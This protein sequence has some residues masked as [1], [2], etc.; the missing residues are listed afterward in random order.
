MY[1]TKFQR[2]VRHISRWP[3]LVGLLLTTACSEPD[4]VNDRI[5]L[6]K[7]NMAR[8][9]YGA[10]SLELANL[11]QS[12]PNHLEARLLQGKVSL[13]AGRAAAAESQLVQAR[14]LGAPSQLLYR[15]IAL[16][17]VAQG[18]PERVSSV[19]G[20]EP[21]IPDDR[22]AWLLAAGLAALHAGDMDRAESHFSHVTR[23]EAD[24]LDGQLGMAAVKRARG[25]LD[26][27]ARHVEKTTRDFPLS[28]AA[29]QALGALRYQQQRLVDAERAF[30]NAIE[31]T[32]GIDRAYEYMLARTGLVETQWHLDKK[33]IA[34]QNANELMDS[35]PWHPLPKY[36]RGLLA[37]LDN[38]YE[39]A[40]DFLYRV[41]TALPDHK[42][43][44]KLLAAINSAQGKLGRAQLYLDKYF[45]LNDNDPE[46]LAL[47]GETYL[48]MGNAEEAVSTVKPLVNTSTREARYLDLYGTA[49][50]YATSCD[51]GGVYLARA[52]AL[53]PA[54]LK[55]QT[56]L[57]AAYLNEG[58]IDSADALMSTWNPP[59]AV[60]EASRQVLRL[61]RFLRSGQYDRAV[62][63][64]KKL[65]RKS[66]ANLH[67]LL[68]LAEIAHLRGEIEEESAWLELARER[69]PKAVEPRLIL[70]YRHMQKRRYQQAVQ[71]LQEA[72]A[73]HPYN[74]TVLRM[75]A[76]SLLNIG[77]HGEALSTA[78]EARRL[79][80]GQQINRLSL[81]H[82]HIISNNHT[83]ARILIR[84]VLDADSEAT[85]LFVPLVLELHSNGFQRKAHETLE[86]LAALGGQDDVL[87][88]TA[89]DLLL[90]ED[91]TA[92]AMKQYRKAGAIKPTPMRT[93]KAK[94]MET[95]GSS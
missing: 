19:I 73:A 77:Q 90:L 22:V 60:T 93:L 26:G 18:E 71:V 24:N 12:R 50:R 6:V 2:R 38:D 23:L 20:S 72:A 53:N 35:Y 87:A 48:Q 45:A 92:Q 83:K 59:G 66:P 84:E 78:S 74:A 33:S 94:L 34:I 68:A 1:L 8:G 32:D 95:S 14:S 9:D 43:S 15:P 51:D 41:V 17:I 69:N 86:V 54:K 7:E 30:I 42:P 11:I 79:A 62:E 61:E 3:V 75:L 47:M 21:T 4:S 49:C 10:A 80:P 13:A 37:Y 55:R 65:R 5:A 52:V 27:A 56:R 46:M 31:G 16:S 89:G 63:Y 67:A 82:A 58:N 85:K 91:Q 44:L 39:L 36:V 28:I 25:D 81:I 64:A 88:E 76:H 29:W 40:G 70:A 57:A